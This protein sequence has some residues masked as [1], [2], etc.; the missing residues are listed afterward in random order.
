MT[1][2][3]TFDV[4]LVGSNLPNGSL[5]RFW[6]TQ[7]G[8]LVNAYGWYY[9]FGNGQRVGPFETSLD[10]RRG[11]DDIMTSTAETE[12]YPVGDYQIDD[13]PERRSP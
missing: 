5:D 7:D 11:A 6:L 3:A 12:L 2:P 4:F 9:Q 13:P 10:A 8:L 1:K